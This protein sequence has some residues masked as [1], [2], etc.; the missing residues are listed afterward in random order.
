MSYGKTM[1]LD[2]I[3]YE[4]VGLMKKVIAICDKLDIN[5]YLA[6]G[7]LI[8]AARHSG[9]IP[10][11]DD[12]DIFMLRPDF[13]KFMKYC[14]EHEEELAPCKLMSRHN[15]PNYPFAIPRFCDLS[16][17]MESD[18]TCGVDMGLFIDVYPYDGAGNDIE[19]ANKKVM[20]K[21]RILSSQLYF[22]QGNQ[23]PKSKKSFLNKMFSYIL[24]FSARNKDPQIYLEKLEKLGTKYDI[25]DSKYIACLVWDTDAWAIE[26]AWCE[27]YELL[28]FEGIKV[29]VPLNYEKV[30][31]IWYTDYR[32]LPPEEARQ[33]HHEYNL[34]RK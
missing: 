27:G 20:F 16:F 4:T 34:Y 6:F 18:I 5:Y 24:Y 1:T 31:D 32:Q 30:L 3:H 29:K 14:T 17:H 9:F 26:K 23:M 12:C 19:Y 10:W 22:A 13:D 15:T 28:D 2:E 11:D 25:K 33:P 21:K 7:T 8:G